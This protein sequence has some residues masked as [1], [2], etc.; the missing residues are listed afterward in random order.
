MSSTR[1]NIVDPILPGGTPVFKIVNGQ[2]VSVGVSTNWTTRVRPVG[3]TE[4]CPTWMDV[5]FVVASGT[6][7]A[8]L[9][10][11]PPIPGVVSSSFSSRDVAVIQLDSNGI[12]IGTDRIPF[13]F[14][15]KF[16]SANPNPIADEI[17]FS[18]VAFP[19]VPEPLKDA[20]VS[21]VETV[22]GNV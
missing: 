6:G 16:H 22:C 4:G 13:V 11:I 17:W 5:I 14:I 8:N 2:K 1:D 10:R 20:D 3:S 12:P 21:N 9:P 7:A 15:P 18:T 19:S